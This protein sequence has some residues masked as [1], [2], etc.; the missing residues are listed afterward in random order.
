MVKIGSETPLQRVVGE[1]GAE[2]G[3]L[4]MDGP[5]RSARMVEP[6]EEK[7][8]KPWSIAAGGAGPGDRVNSLFSALR[9]LEIWERRSALQKSAKLH[10]G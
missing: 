7:A 1:L 3:E 5:R 6:G 2:V 8:N 10:E 9:W 4:G